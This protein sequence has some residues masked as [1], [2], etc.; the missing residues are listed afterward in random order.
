MIDNCSC[1]NKALHCI[2]YRLDQSLITRLQ[3]Y[4]ATKFFP[5]H[6]VASVM[7][8]VQVFWPSMFKSKRGVWIRRT[9]QMWLACNV[10]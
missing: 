9:K 10:F 8:S 7:K 4:E 2:D 6:T 1:L 3:I 5:V